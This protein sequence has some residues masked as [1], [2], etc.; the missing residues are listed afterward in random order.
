MVETFERLR[1]GVLALILLGCGGEWESGTVGK[2][3]CSFGSFDDFLPAAHRPVKMASG[4]GKL[5]ILDD[6]YYVH[7]YKR[8]NLYECAFNLEESHGFSG[9]PNDVFSAGNNFYVQDRAVLKFLDDEVACNANRN[10]VFAIHGNELAVG[11]EIGLEVWN[12][13]PCAKKNNVS[14]QRV[15]ALAATDSEYFAVEGITAQPINLTRY[16]KSGG[17]SSSD[18]MS[19]TS[20]NEKHFCS[21]DRL[22]AN[23]YG[24]YLLDK[25]CRK[26]G[27]YDNQ[28]V[29]RKTISLDSLS[30]RNVIDITPAEYSYIFILHT[31]GVVKVNVF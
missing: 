10:G 18:P 16:P 3:S 29:W 7:S 30:I 8:D 12:I 15:L 27:V 23:N 19:Q 31:S 14:S 24:V 13:N 4:N 22:V 9:F 26:I 28:A 1:Y 21:A 20:G 2:A 17:F 11:S 6:F 5:Y 25:T